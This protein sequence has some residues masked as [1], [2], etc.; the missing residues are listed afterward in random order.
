MNI[1]ISPK[2]VWLAVL[3]V[4]PAL[5]A[6]EVHW[7]SEGFPCAPDDTKDV[8]AE[9]RAKVNDLD[10][11]GVV[12]IGSSRVLYDLQ[13]YVWESMT[14]HRPVQLAI[15][16]ASPLPVLQDL[17]ERTAFNGTVVV[18]VTP[19][20][21]FGSSGPGRGSWDHPAKNVDYYYHRTLAQ[22][23]NFWVATPLQ[24]HLAFLDAGDMY[25]NLDL[26]TLIQ[27]IPWKGRIREDLPF[28]WFKIIDDNRSVTM[29]DKVTAD[30]AYAGMIRRVWQDFS[31]G[32]P[33]DSAQMANTKRA[34]LDMT[35]RDINLIRQRGG[36]VV[37]VRCPSSAW[38]RDMENNLFPR[39]GYWDVLLRE[40]GAPGYHF[41][42]NAALNKYFCPEWSHLATPDAK[43]F[44]R[45]L[46]MQM[47]QDH[48]LKS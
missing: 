3:L 2:T 10:S 18:G 16:G 9:A 8:W 17:A 40:T 11:N 35:V 7:R 46:V 48:I 44:T 26:K 23:F 28:P 19:G 32:P 45:S 42:D 43:A 33:P 24:H 25:N 29:R 47:L 13:I 41:E 12:L 30:T 5:I 4:L 34:V 37:F 14:G 36:Q 27:R 39:S 1:V 15:P 38:Y 21:F 6:W 31:S 20:L 22:R